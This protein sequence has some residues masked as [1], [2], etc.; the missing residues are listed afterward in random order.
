MMPF[1]T[2]E[3]WRRLPLDDEARADS[4]MIA[5]WPDPSELARFADEGAEHTIGALQEIVSAIRAVRSRYN[6]APKTKID[7][8][9]KAGGADAMLIESLTGQIGS[10]AGATLTVSADAE[11][12]AHSATA[13]AASSE[14]FVPLEGL[15]DFDA[16]RARVGKALEKTRTD[17]EKLDKKLSNEGFLSKA[18]PEIVEKDRERA[19]ELRETVSTLEAQLAELG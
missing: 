10:L 16:E 17:L 3:I 12:P 15:V 7:V 14:L 4:L 13:V 5:A 9:V 8:A 1:V 18:A 19:A 11:K 2:E 6:V